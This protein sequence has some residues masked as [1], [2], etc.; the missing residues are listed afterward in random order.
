M[1]SFVLCKVIPNE[2]DQTLSAK[3]TAVL[4]SRGQYASGLTDV[5]RYTNCLRQCVFLRVHFK[6]F[7]T[8]VQVNEFAQTLKHANS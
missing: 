3:A 2:K 5:T 7:I 6:Y 8:E 4:V 1:T